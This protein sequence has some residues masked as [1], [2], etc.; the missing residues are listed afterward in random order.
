MYHSITLVGN[1]GRDPEMRY[2][3]DGTPVT[4]M[5]VA[6][7]DSFGDAQKTIWFRVS[8]WRA[9]AEACNQYLSKGSKVLVVGRLNHDNGNPRTFT[10]KDGSAGASFEITASTVKFLSSKG[11]AGGD[12]APRDEDIPPEAKF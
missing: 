3:P 7:D 9:Q 10:R 1:L 4:T 12:S 2:T 11:G 6:V 5:S 8:V